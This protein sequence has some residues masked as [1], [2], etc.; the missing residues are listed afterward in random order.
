MQT[1]RKAGAAES[2]V[3]AI[4]QAEGVKG[5]PCW[6]RLEYF[7]WANDMLLDYMHIT[8]NNGH[9]IRTMLA[10][11]DPNP[12]ATM[13]AIKEVSPHPNM[14]FVE[15]SVPLLCVNTDINMCINAHAPLLLLLFKYVQTCVNPLKCVAQGGGFVPHWKLPDQ[16]K[17]EAHQWLMALKPPRSWGSEHKRALK[18][19]NTNPDK[20][21]ALKA[22]TN[23]VLLGSGI[24]SVLASWPRPEGSTSG[25][26]VTKFVKAV[27]QT[28][29]QITRPALQAE[30]STKKHVFEGLCTYLHMFIDGS[31]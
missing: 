16:S 20:A 10:Q 30:V 22:H 23:H 19:S 17:E 9:R 7:D 18:S 3:K 1:L 31:E 27:Q 2:V 15:V 28:H 5:V 25:A 8:K 12:S 21:P 11:A 13:Q 6:T 4:I 26:R 24:L 29:R 14:G